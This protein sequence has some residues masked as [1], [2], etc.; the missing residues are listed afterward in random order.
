MT[1]RLGCIVKTTSENSS[2]PRVHCEN[3]E[4]QLTE[5]FDHLRKDIE[6]VDEPQFK[7]LCETSAEVIGALRRS[8]EHY[9]QRSEP[10][11]QRKP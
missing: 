3:I 7:A 6:R 10:A 9:T 5:I 4:R 8:F 1:L 11:W 2:D